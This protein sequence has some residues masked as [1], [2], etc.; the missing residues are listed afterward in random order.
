MSTRSSFFSGTCWSRTTHRRYCSFLELRWH[1]CSQI[2]IVS[3]EFRSTVTQSRLQLRGRRQCKPSWSS[4][5]RCGCQSVEPCGRER[6]T[7]H[8]SRRKKSGREGSPR[9]I[10]EQNR[11]EFRDEVLEPTTSMNFKKKP[12]K[13]VIF[14]Q[15]VRNVLVCARLKQVCGADARPS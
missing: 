10:E 7:K 6:H 14:Q 13:P 4:R 2:L 9:K 1:R 3:R 11:D 15:N 12:I 5:R 8:A